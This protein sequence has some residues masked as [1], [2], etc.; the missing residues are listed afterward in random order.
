MG[1]RAAVQP[2]AAANVDALRIAIL[3]IAALSSFPILPWVRENPRLAYSIWGAAA[4]LLVFLG[5][6][7]RSAAA[8]GRALR[9]EFVPRPVHYVQLAMH[10]S[11]Y[12][13]WGWYWR[14]VYHN[15]PLIVAQI[16]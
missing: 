13:Y 2:Q 7:W 3:P 6:L 11:I 12:V 5:A 16:A 8:R 9:F 10:T 14:E 4:V 1:T 15:A